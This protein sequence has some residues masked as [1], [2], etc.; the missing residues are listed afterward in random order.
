M[1]LLE[2]NKCLI[3]LQNWLRLAAL[4]RPKAVKYGIH[5]AIIIGNLKPFEGLPFVVQSGVNLRE[6]V[7]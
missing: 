4:I 3:E 6:P 7:G 2:R 5:R 1:A